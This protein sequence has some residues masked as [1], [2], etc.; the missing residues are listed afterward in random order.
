MDTSVKFVDFTG[1]PGLYVNNLKAR[2]ASPN[3]EGHLYFYSSMDKQLYQW[4]ANQLPLVQPGEV[5][6]TNF[7]DVIYGND[8]K[9]FY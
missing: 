9:I 2:A 3:P 6:F 7:S 4:E 1:V 5:I 8:G